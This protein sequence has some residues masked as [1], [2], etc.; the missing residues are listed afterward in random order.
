MEKFIPGKA[1]LDLLKSKTGIVIPVFFPVGVDSSKGE[2]LLRETTA[3]FAALVKDPSVIWLSVDGEQAGVGIAR[4]V[5]DMTGANVTFGQENRGKLQAASNGVKALLGDS[6]CDYVAIIDQDGDHFPHEMPNFVSA[7]VHIEEVAGQPAFILGRRVS[8]HKPMGFPRGEL[9]EFAD[10]VLVDTLSYH[11]AVTGKPLRMECANVFDEFPDFHSGYKLF[12]RDIAS[13]I[14]ADP[15]HKAG[16]SDI[17]FYRHACEAVMSVEALLAGAY[18]GVVN[19][20]TVYEQPITTFGL[21]NRINLVADKIIW[22][23]KRL[24]IPSEFV[25]Q[26]MHNHIPRLQLMTLTPDGTNELKAIRDTVMKEFDSDWVEGQELLK[27][28]FV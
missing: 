9:E 17:C 19:R 1:G 7:A 11:A 28:I 13:K 4:R 26:W 14:F 3:G 21:M 12:S 2:A 23:C 24:N 10:R 5:A 16:V 25:K 18:L 20:S 15:F 27:P 22:P 6:D 8:R